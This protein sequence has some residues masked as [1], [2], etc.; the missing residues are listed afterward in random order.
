MSSILCE[1]LTRK[2]EQ[3][4]MDPVVIPGFV[5][6]LARSV[7]NDGPICIHQVKQRMKYLGWDGWELDYHALQLALA[8][9]EEENLTDSQYKSETW[10]QERF[11]SQAVWRSQAGLS[12]H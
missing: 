5:R 12:P 10:Y 11:Q 7:S 2:L 6:S 1:L 9:F 8:C 3:N 4:G